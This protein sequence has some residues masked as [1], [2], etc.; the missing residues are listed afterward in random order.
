[1]IQALIY[2]I[3]G[4]FLFGGLAIVVIN[5]RNK[6]YAARDRWV[7]YIFYLLV[8]S[9]TVACIFYGLL[10]LLALA[11]AGTGLYEML[12][13]WLKTARSRALLWKGLGVYIPVAV[14]FCL[15]AFWQDTDVLLFVYTIVFVFDG[16]AQITGQLLGRKKIFPVI[17]PEKTRAG[18][19]GGYISVIV[20][21]LLLKGITGLPVPHLVI[22]TLVLATAAMTGDLLASLYKRKC[23]VKDYSRLIPGHGGILD[24]FDSYMM[25]G[26]VCWLIF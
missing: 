25:A 17:S 20:T 16:F 8:V 24:R 5:R 14:T 26:A 9:A 10:P 11:I 13:A 4:Y 23:G 2:I 3:A 7:K 6:L 15:H 19:I 21:S 22:K 1:M 12:T 18:V